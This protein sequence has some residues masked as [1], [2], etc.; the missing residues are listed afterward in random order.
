MDVFTCLCVY[1][2]AFI[3]NNYSLWK[4][5][6]NYRKKL[7]LIYAC[8]SGKPIKECIKI[9]N[10]GIDVN[11]YYKKHQNAIYYAFI[12]GLC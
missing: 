3:H 11:Y 10:N 6:Y 8:V 2:F 4:E 5:K 1:S 9:I 7:K 12:N